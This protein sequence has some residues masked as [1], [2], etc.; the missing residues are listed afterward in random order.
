M[1]ITVGIRF[2]NLTLGLMELIRCAGETDMDHHSCH[3]EES[4]EPSAGVT[5]EARPFVF[6]HLKGGCSSESLSL[7]D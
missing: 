3:S 2:A 6:L 7:N 5:R 4:L 1:G